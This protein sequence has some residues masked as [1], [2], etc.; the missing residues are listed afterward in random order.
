MPRRTIVV[1]E[2]VLRT[3]GYGIIPV[4]MDSHHHQDQ[5]HD[6]NHGHNQHGHQFTPLANLRQ[7]MPFWLKM[8]L[9]VMG[10]KNISLNGQRIKIL[11]FLQKI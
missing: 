7:P 3:S 9:L 2:S 10:E 8:A 11:Y 4:N 6:E 5:D 1:V